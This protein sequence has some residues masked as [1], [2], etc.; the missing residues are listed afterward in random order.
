[1]LEVLKKEFGSF[2]NSLA[3]YIVLVIFFII[4]GLFSWVFPQSSILS[5]GFANLNPLFDLAPYLF[6][7]LV[8]ALTMK[9]FSEEVKTGTIELLLT[10]PLTDWS[11]VLGKYFASLT[12]IIIAL[13]PTLVYYYTV[14][15]IGSPIGN[16]D[17]GATIGSYFGLLLLGTVFSA[18]GILASSITDNQIV[19]Y[20]TALFLCFIIYDGF[21]LISSINIWST[22]SYQISKWGIDHHYSALSKG[23]IDSRNI[24]YFISMTLIML[25]AS[26]ITLSSRKW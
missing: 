21:S 10:K 23:I 11:I 17:Q 2:F 14:Y 16:I 22:Y 8:P 5:N 13:L 26:K 24:L 4:T 9:A 12:L 25:F 18:I 15:Q 1:M 20:I 19:S 6:M 7:F 3:G